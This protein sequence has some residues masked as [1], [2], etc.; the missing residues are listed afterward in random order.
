[1]YLK[2][3][4]CENVGFIQIFLEKSPGHPTVGFHNSGILY[5]ELRTSSS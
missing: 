2:D 5:Y 4:R 1:M 3:M